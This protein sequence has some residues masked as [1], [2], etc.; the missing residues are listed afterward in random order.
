M[1]IRRFLGLLW[2]RILIVVAVTAQA[3][4]I[5]FIVSRAL[6]PSY[7]AQA[8]IVV[9]AGMGTGSTST[10][11]VLTAPRIGQTFAGLGTT[12]PVLEALIKDLD[13]PYSSTDLESR[14]SVQAQ[15]DAPFITVG[16]QDQ[17]PKRAA[18]IANGLAAALVD[19]SKTTPV[20]ATGG[21]DATGE[22]LAL[23]SIVE[24][25]EVPGD[26]SSPRVWFNTV[27]AA[28]AAF[29]ISVA[30]LSVLAYLDDRIRGPSDLEGMP[31]ALLGRV[32]LNDEPGSDAQGMPRGLGAGEAVFAGLVNHLLPGTGR[33][34]FTSTTGGR[35]AGVT[36]AGLA[37]A[38]A[39]LGRRT[40]LVD[41]NLREPHL[42]TLFAVD[43]HRGLATLLGGGGTAVAGELRRTA[44]EGLRLLPAGP[45]LGDPEDLLTG[46]RTAEVLGALADEGDLVVVATAPAGATADA[47]IIAAL[48]D[49]TILVVNQGSTTRGQLQSAIA[50][51]RGVGGRILGLVLMVPPTG[52]GEPAQGELVFGAEGTA[53]SR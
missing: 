11:A 30:L 19:L 6:P 3:A 1:E 22:P 27:L 51:L 24:P 31:A 13:L 45:V 10:D 41:A 49:S 7:E 44:I 47:T 37:I 9:D 32:R 15:F 50:G 17:D 42:H 14:L 46:R 16:A 2:A 36:A 26:P 12:R 53:S 35:G 39:H 25:A 28:I 34:S 52:R 48:V 29:A 4:V 33:V 38:A 8:T 18:A 43:N 21:T 5:A 40:V 23:L 20:G